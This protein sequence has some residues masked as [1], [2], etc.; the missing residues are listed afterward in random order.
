MTPINLLGIERKMHKR[1][2][3]TI[4]AQYVQG[5]LRICWNIII[6]C[7]KLLGINETKNIRW[8]QTI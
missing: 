3:N 2:K 1:V 4:L 7:P 8:Q 6:G 5:L